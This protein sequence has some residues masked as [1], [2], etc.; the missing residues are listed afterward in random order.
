M[1]GRT[2]AGLYGTPCRVHD[3]RVGE[4]VGA[5]VDGDGERVLGLQVRSAGGV[6]RF[7]PWVA[8]EFDDRGVSIRSAFLLVDDGESYGRLGA[9][10]ISD[11]SELAELHVDAAGRVRR[12][13]GVVSAG[14][15]VGTPLR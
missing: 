5:Y 3:V 10:V 14:A 9:H 11:P 1:S 15:V 6:R 4:V 7:L 8:T 13:D 12:V 2:L